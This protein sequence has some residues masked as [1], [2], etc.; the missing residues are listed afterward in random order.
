MLYTHYFVN[1]H[2]L[3]QNIRSNSDPNYKFEPGIESTDISVHFIV[4][5]TLFRQ[6]ASVIEIGHRNVGWRV[7]SRRHVFFCRLISF[8]SDRHA[9]FPLIQVYVLYLTCKDKQQ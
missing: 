9:S 5:Q 2:A 8:R 4:F 1:K 7:L 6:I 3:R